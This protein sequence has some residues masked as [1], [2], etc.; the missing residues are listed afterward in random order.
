[1]RE[2]EARNKETTVEVEEREER[3]DL[4]WSVVNRSGSLS[5]CC[6]WSLCGVQRSVPDSLYELHLAFTKPGQ[7]VISP[8]MMKVQKSSVT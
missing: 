2:D 3:C 7:G 6:V 5:L 1:M 4:Q 8:H